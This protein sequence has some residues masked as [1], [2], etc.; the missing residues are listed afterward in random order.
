MTAGRYDTCALLSTGRT[1]CWGD[2]DYGQ[3]GYA[4]TNRIGDN[5]QPTAGGNISI[6]N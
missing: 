5:E 2:N 6:L 3:L 4:N 1:W